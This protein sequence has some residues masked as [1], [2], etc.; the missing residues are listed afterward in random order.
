MA[1]ILVELEYG[2]LVSVKG[3]KLEIPDK[4]PLSK[5]RTSKTYAYG[6][7][8]TALHYVQYGTALDCVITPKLK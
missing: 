8:Q 5:A 1:S 4:N 3:G 6:M 7:H 2:V